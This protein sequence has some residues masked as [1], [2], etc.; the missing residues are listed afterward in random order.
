MHLKYL[1]NYIFYYYTYTITLK[2]SPTKKLKNE[3]KLQTK[4]IQSHQNPKFFIEVKILV[5]SRQRNIFT[6]T[7]KK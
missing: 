6:K 2:K 5:I 4:N 3:Q 1:Q 7:L